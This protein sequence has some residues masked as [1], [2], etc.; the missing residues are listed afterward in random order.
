MDAA[1]DKDNTV[2]LPEGCPALAA[3]IN[4]RAVDDHRVAVVC[5]NAE[6]AAPVQ[7]AG[8]DLHASAVLECQH[9]ARAGARFLRVPCGEVQQ[10]DI[11]AELEAQHVCIPRHGG[12]RVVERR[13]AVVRLCRVDSQVAHA[14]DD[15]LRPVIAVLPEVILAARCAVVGSC[16]EVVE[17][18]FQNNGS[19]AADHR[20]EFVHG[21][22]V[23]GTVSRRG[24]QLFL[25]HTGGGKQRLVFTDGALHHALQLFAAEGSAFCINGKYAA[26][27]IPGVDAV[28]GKAAALYHGAVS[29]AG[30]HPAKEAVLL[31]PVAGKHHIAGIAHHQQA[32][33]V[34]VFHNGVPDHNVLAGIR[35]EQE[36]DRI[37]PCCCMVADGAPVEEH[38]PRPVQINS[39]V[40]AV[41]DDAVGYRHV[42]AVLGTDAQHPAAEHP[43][44]VNR[45]LP[46]VVKAE[47]VPCAEGRGFR[48]PCGKALQGY[49]VAGVEVQHGRIARY[50]GN[51][52]LV[53][54][55]ALNGQITEAFDHQ[56]ISVIGILPSP[57][58]TM[59]LSAV[60]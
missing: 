38:V 27:L 35:L 43:A 47:H 51:R 60:G 45:C 21:V 31:H 40:G 11:L 33:G 25:I 44:L 53:H 39:A 50:S 13:I 48:M 7:P 17:L 52:N 2:C 57:V 12:N 9:P 54:T 19:V 14:R 59:L 32:L 58:V 4:L 34:V 30:E 41:I 20:Q 26:A 55:L 42:R 36:A 15:Q 1:V 24:D 28:V 5:V 3:V 37:G 16:G 46:A 8:A 22:H 18:R 49:V 56:L 23:V 10:V 6:D 29:V